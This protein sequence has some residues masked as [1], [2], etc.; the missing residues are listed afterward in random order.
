MHKVDQ[1]VLLQ[2]NQG[3]TILWSSWALSVLI[4]IP[5]DRKK[6]E[7]KSLLKIKSTFND[8]ILD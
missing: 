1:M 3:E 6:N 4:R 5:P 8:F 2:A 7:F